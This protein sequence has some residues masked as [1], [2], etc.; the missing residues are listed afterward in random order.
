MTKLVDTWPILC[1][2]SFTVSERNRWTK[3]EVKSSLMV[4]G[5]M[6]LVR[7]YFANVMFRKE[8]SIFCYLMVNKD[9]YIH[10]VPKKGR[11]QTH[12]RNSVIS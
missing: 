11:H 7:F 2:L 6:C 9:E 12:G 1:Q 10:R 4:L 5:V 3:S 8:S